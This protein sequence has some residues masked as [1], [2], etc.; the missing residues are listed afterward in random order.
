MKFIRKSALLAALLGVCIVPLGAFAQSDGRGDDKREGKLALAVF[1][2]WPYSRILLDNASLL[3]NSINADSKVSRVI[4]VGDIHSGS[5]PCTSAGI[6]PP[7]SASNPGW[8]QGV[9]ALM[10]RILPPVVYLPGDNEWVDCHKSKQFSSGDPLK[11]LASVRQL[12]FARPGRTLGFNEAEVIS[13]AESY[14]VGHPE[15]AEYVENVRWQMDK[16]TFVTLNVPGGSN[17]DQS[18]WTG[19]FANPDAQAHERTTR[20]AANLRWLRAAFDAAGKNRSKAMV[21]A[22]QADMW[23]PEATAVGGAGLGGYTTLV[24]AIADFTLAFGKPV[25]LINGDSHVYFY[26]HPLADPTNR[27]GLIHGTPAVPNLTRITVQGST[28]APAEWL[29]L[30]ID[31]QAPTVFSWRNVPYC[32]DPLTSCE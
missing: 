23:D 8:N 31:T 27:T 19:V 24:R 25:L 6:L 14:D 5:M 12:F 18:P 30:T 9:Y 22:L 28:T 32:R 1:G 20:D 10:Q 7:I 15:D 13:Q 17:D 4:H 2:D 21:I 16:T 11:E 26:D 29:R 3:I